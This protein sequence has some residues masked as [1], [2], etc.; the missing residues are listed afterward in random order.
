[1]RRSFDPSQVAPLLAQA[2]DRARQAARLR[3]E[4]PEEPAGP[5]R[6]FLAAGPDWELD[7][8]RV[9]IYGAGS[10]G[11]RCR[12]QLATRADVVAFVDSDQTRDGTSVDG[13]PVVSPERL[14]DLDPD[15][16]IV[17]SMYW[18]QILNRLN[19]C[20]WDDERVR[21]F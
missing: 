21:V 19:D 9:A 5:L 7:G 2:I 20:G 8:Q 15:V 14:D 4:G 10:L 3:M 12:S 17:A 1:V 6:R 11:R 13:L 18:P 16:V